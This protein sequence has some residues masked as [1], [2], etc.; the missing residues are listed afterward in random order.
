MCVDEYVH[1]P[2][3]DLTKSIVNSDAVSECVKLLILKKKLARLNNALEKERQ[4]RHTAEN[5]LGNFTPRKRWTNKF[6]LYKDKM[7]T[8]FK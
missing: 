5:Q 7:D 6:E 2:N 4:Y 1:C 3:E 8:S